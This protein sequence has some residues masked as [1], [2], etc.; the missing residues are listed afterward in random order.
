MRL[1]V[2]GHSLRCVRILVAF[3]VRASDESNSSIIA[4]MLLSID[5]V[6]CLLAGQTA[7]QYE[8]PFLHI[9]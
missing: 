8:S 3:N 9:P 1:G 6:T 7:L 5:A 4:E 2:V